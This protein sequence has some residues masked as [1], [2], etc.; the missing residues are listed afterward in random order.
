MKTLLMALLLTAT[1]PQTVD[2]CAGLKAE[3]CEYNSERLF[4]DVSGQLWAG[5]GS[6]GSDIRRRAVEYCVDYPDA[7]VVIQLGNGRSTYLCNK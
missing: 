1:S 4:V 6:L 7:R 5:A 3:S 2:Y